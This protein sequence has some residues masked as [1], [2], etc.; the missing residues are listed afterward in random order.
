MGNWQL[1]LVILASVLVGAFIPLLVM[2]ASAIHRAGR[3]FADIGARLKRTL[4]KVELISD[5][6]EVLSRGF[7]GKE[8]DLADALTSVGNLA[9][10]LDRNMKLINIFSTIIASVGTVIAAFVK[11]RFP[12]EE[13]REPPPSGA[14]PEKT[15]DEDSRP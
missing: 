2:L 13:T 14:S 3:E 15:T 5:R 10:G 9:R 8:A 1:A 6:V 12:A 11:T 4:T 7:E